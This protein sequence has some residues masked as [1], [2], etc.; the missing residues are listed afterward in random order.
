MSTFVSMPVTKRSAV[1]LSFI[2]ANGMGLHW[3]QDYE[4]DHMVGMAFKSITDYLT[5][6]EDSPEDW[7]LSLIRGNSR[8]HKLFLFYL[9]D[10]AMLETHRIT[11]VSPI[12]KTHLSGSIDKS[13]SPELLASLAPYPA[14]TQTANLQT[15]LS[16]TAFSQ[17]VLLSMDPSHRSP[18]S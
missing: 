4:Q 11:R 10:L 1:L 14:M 17:Q 15:H 16:S 6:L 13:T 9:A 2:G 8:V 5:K 7:H 12:F 3:I 18:E